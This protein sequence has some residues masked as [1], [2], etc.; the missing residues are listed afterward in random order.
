MALSWTAGLA[1]S[2]TS[3]LGSR[4]AIAGEQRQWH[5]VTLTFA[6]PNVSETSSVNPFRNYRLNVTFKHASSGRS[7]VVPG[8]FAADGNAAN[9]SAT[10]GSKWRV[11]FAPDATG[12]WT[13]LASFRTGSDVAASTSSTAGTATRFTG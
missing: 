11:H 12:T 13:Y 6:G 3:S 10:A 1:F 4:T 9:T 8:Y 2:A 5:K 7:L